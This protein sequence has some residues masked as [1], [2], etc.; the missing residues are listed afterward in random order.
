M[1][2]SVCVYAGLLTALWFAY[3]QNFFPEPGQESFESTVIK[4]LDIT[5]HLID[6]VVP[7]NNWREA[8]LFAAYMAS[9]TAFQVRGHR[10]ILAFRR[11][12]PCR[13]S[14]GLKWYR[15]MYL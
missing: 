7:V 3:G 14:V 2:W 10:C 9:W 6:L 15:P 8:Q 1:L 11:I 13:F 12:I 4:Y 5:Y